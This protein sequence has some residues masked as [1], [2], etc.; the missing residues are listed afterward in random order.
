MQCKAVPWRPRI[1]FP[2][3][4]PCSKPVIARY[5]SPRTRDLEKAAP[6]LLLPQSQ[7]QYRAPAPGQCRVD[8]EYCLD[9]RPPLTPMVAQSHQKHG[10]RLRHRLIGSSMV[11][12][13]QWVAPVALL[14]HRRPM[15]SRMEAP[16]PHR[17]SR[18]DFVSSSSPLEA[19]PDR[20][21]CPS[22]AKLVPSH[23]NYTYTCAS[24]EMAR[25]W[26][27]RSN[28]SFG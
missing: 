23:C 26:H 27:G 4:D 14:A 1:K 9:C 12:L 21:N 25:R 6:L 10:R 18:L 8:G 15:A 17:R 3:R 16:W 22:V 5:S 11:V 20:M 7:S 24:T 28:L 13:V 2:S 19:G